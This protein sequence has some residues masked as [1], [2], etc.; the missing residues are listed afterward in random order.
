M[1]AIEFT[2][3]EVDERCKR[4]YPAKA[5]KASA[6]GILADVADAHGVALRDVLGREMTKHVMAARREL[7]ARLRGLGWS[8]PSIGRFCGGRDHTTIML[9]LRSTGW[10]G[11]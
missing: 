9:G 2:P 8:Y 7:Y 11:K 10:A 1:S 5:S 3:E 6:E 4:F